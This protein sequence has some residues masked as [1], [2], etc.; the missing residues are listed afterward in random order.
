MKNIYYMWWSIVATLV[1]GLY[2]PLAAYSAPL[3]TNALVMTMAA[4]FNG[5]LLTMASSCAE[6]AGGVTVI[7]DAVLQEL[8]NSIAIRIPTINAALHNTLLLRIGTAVVKTGHGN[9]QQSSVVF[10]DINLPMAWQGQTVTLDVKRLSIIKYLLINKHMNHCPYDA[11]TLTLIHNKLGVSLDSILDQSTVKSVD[12]LKQYGISLAE[13]EDHTNVLLPENSADAIVDVTS[14]LSHYDPLIVKKVVRNKAI[15]SCIKSIP[16]A[17]GMRFLIDSSL[18]Y[19]FL[20]TACAVMPGLIKPGSALLHSVA[21]GLGVSGLYH[22]ELIHQ[23]H[24]CQLIGARPSAANG[25]LLPSMA[26]A[27]GSE[28]VKLGLSD[29]IKNQV[30]HGAMMVSLLSWFGYAHA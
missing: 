28:V 13:N 9:K 5:K 19:R 4:V 6:R 11:G 12:E 22:T 17:V 24:Q 29:I 10:C 8:G 3:V 1:L 21:L 27:V 25:F 7:D 16:V 18:S 15:A 23:G 30:S 20:K 14:I 26:G 2:T